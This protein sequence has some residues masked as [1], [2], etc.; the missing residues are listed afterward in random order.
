MDTLFALYLFLYAVGSIGMVL[1][2]LVKVR[3]KFPSVLATVIVVFFG[4]MVVLFI[5]L[6]LEF[7]MAPLTGGVDAS[8]GYM[9]KISITEE[10]MKI[11]IVFLGIFIA[12]EES[13]WT[14]TKLTLALIA[15]IVFG[16]VEGLGYVFNYNYTPVGTL[17]LFATRLHHAILTATLMAGILL[18]TKGRKLEGAVIA[19]SPY[20][21]HAFFD[22][23][24]SV[25]NYVGTSLMVIV[26]FVMFFAGIR[27]LL[28]VIKEEKRTRERFQREATVSI[29]DNWFNKM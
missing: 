10:T 5:D 17:I 26:S 22:Y 21:V 19:V 24:V 18:I 29:K 16:I 20:L 1:W 4:V 23:F 9:F 3:P 25:R 2:F 28:P 11:L 7:A 13:T 8:L 15:G 12:R 14:D 27:L 6:I